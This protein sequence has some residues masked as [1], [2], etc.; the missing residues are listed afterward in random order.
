MKE[1]SRSSQRPSFLL[2][3]IIAV[4]VVGTALVFHKSLTRS[5]SPQANEGL[6]AASGAGDSGAGAE[7]TLTQTPTQDSSRVGAVTV[8]ALVVP[9]GGSGSNDPE[10]ESIASDWKTTTARLKELEECERSETCN[11]P[12][13]T[14]SD[15]TYAVNEALAAELRHFAEVAQRW[16]EKN[17]G[18]IPQEAEQVA[19]HFLASPADEVKEAAIDFLAVTPPSPENMRAIVNGLRDSVSGPLYKTGLEELVRYAGSENAAEV[20]A[21]LLDTLKHGGHY[22]ADEV[23]QASLPFMNESNVDQYRA[24]LRDLSPRSSAYMH[25]KLNLEEWARMQR[26]G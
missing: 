19:R 11:F 16:Q 12:Q 5:S 20:N 25:I 6:E 15:Y 17:G 9:Q 1:E 23:A 26:G 14:P 8:P 10:A 22:A 21:F 13:D 2:V 4:V 18:H 7:S 3:A 24:L